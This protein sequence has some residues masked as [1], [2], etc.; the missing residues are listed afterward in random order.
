MIGLNYNY[1]VNNLTMETAHMTIRQREEIMEE[2][3]ATEAK[4]NQN[5][6][7]LQDIMYSLSIQMDLE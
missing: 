2:V 7:E 1:K 6:K 5:S 3:E 4:I